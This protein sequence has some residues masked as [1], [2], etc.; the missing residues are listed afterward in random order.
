M[1][2]IIYVL[3]SFGLYKVGKLKGIDYPWMAFLPIFNL[4]FVGLLG[5]HFKYTDY[6][7]NKYLGNIPLSLAMP[8]IVIIGSILGRMPF[9][10][11]MI[12]AAVALVTMV[13]NLIVLY[14]IYA[15]YDYQ[16]RV[17]FTAISIIP[18]APTIL[19][20]YVTREYKVL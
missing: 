20:L 5:D 19:V 13:L 17:L 1:S 6:N 4:Y 18:L 7:I 8:G 15:H 11:A 14:L 9:F 10:G 12:A 16:N 3:N 2:L